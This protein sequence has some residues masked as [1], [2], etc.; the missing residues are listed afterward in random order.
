[1]N[2]KRIAGIVLAAGVSKRMREPKQLLKWRGQT[3]IERVARTALASGLD[4]VVVVVGAHGEMVRA[5]VRTLPLLIIDNPHWPEGMSTSMH[6]GLRAL[7]GEVDAA[8]LLLVDQPGLEADHLKAIVEAYQTSGKPIVASS[9]QGRRTSPT[10]FDRS[11]FEDLL[12]IGGDEGGRSI[13]RVRSQ[14]VEIVESVQDLADV[15]TTQDWQ[16]IIGT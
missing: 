8:I 12:A 11:I 3:L 13:V 6:A 7:P 15:D 2:R 4:P 9:F 1:M 5:A 14:Q 16:R 10:L